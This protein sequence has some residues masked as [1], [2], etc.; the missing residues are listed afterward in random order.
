MPWLG[1]GRAEAS[2]AVVKI[3]VI[4]IGLSLLIENL[5]IA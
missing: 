1:I 2:D 4:L 5:V 3:C